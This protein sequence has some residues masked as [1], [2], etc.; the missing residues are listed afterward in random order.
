MRRLRR[1]HQRYVKE[2]AK[3][4]GKLKNRALAAG[5]AAA[6]TLATGMS[7]SKAFAGSDKHQLPVSR[8]ADA[9]LLANKEEL[10]IGYRVFKGDQNRNEIADGA[11]L[12]ERCGAVISGLPWREE[13][14]PGQTYKWC[15]WQF[16]TETCDICGATVNMGPAGITNPQLGL[17]VD[18]PLI[19]M[20]YMEHGSFSYAGDVHHGRLD[21]PALLRALEVRYPYDPNAHQLPLYTD[22]LDADLLADTE[23]L[24]AGYDLYDADQDEDL[25]PDGIE[26]AKQCTQVIDQLPVVGPHDPPPPEIYKVEHRERGLEICDIC[27]AAVNMGTVEVINPQLALL[28]IEFPFLSLHYMSHG[29]F[30][31]SG[32]VH[33]GRVDAGL[34]VKVLQMPVQCGHL[35]TI[36]LPG[37]LNEDCGVDFK[38]VGH[39]ANTWLESTDPNGGGFEY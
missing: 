3:R 33:G 26:L 1:A 12:A 19:A 4:S 37:D 6:I 22:D 28:R 24:A 34:L 5:A 17:S 27:G 9:D 35:G 25:T 32:D 2:Q 11:E 13:A 38:D 30:S 15:D 21:L 18:C 36:Y 23:E 10:A 16:G 8:D 7:V 20:H 29:S 14:L 31:Y 39:M